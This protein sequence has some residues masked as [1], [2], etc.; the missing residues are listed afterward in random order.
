[1]DEL[2]YA[3]NT[4]FNANVLYCTLNFGFLNVP[5]LYESDKCPYLLVSEQWL[6]GTASC[7]DLNTHQFKYNHKPTDP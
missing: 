2:L 4:Q 3:I 7:N 1:M 5:E 6:L